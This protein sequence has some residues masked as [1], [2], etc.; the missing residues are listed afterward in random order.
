MVQIL[1]STLREG[2]QTPGVY[3]SPDS[4]LIIARLLDELGVDIIEAGNP[5]VDDE[6]AQSITM[7][8]H[9]GL[10]A[11]VGAHSRCRIDDVKKALHCGVNFIGIF[12]S[13]SEQRLKYD[14][15]I[16]LDEAITQITDVIRYARTQSDN[17]LIRYTA[18]DAVRSPIDNVLKAS[19]AATEA[20]ANIISIA[21][22]TG[23][24][25][26]FKE[27]RKISDYVRILKTELSKK[28]LH[29]KIA[30]HCHNDRGLALANAL[31]A[32]KAGADIIDATVLRL[33]ERTG[34]V[35][36]A[37]LLMNF[38][39]GFEEGLHWR[40]GILK[41][42]Y[43]LVSEYA[44]IPI[45]CNQP[46][47]GK[48]AF[49]H[50]S[51]LHIRALRRDPWLYQSIDPALFDRRWQITLGVQSGRAAVELALERIG[52][53]DVVDN[54]DLVGAIVKEIKAIAKRGRPIDIEEEFPAI[55]ERCERD[56]NFGR[57]HTKY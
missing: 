20:G 56:N 7:I 54:K 57:C 6:I 14:Y 15:N 19:I 47:T 50:C 21:D 52:R 38:R 1:D 4:K 8:A 30:V 22:T 31:D 34:I 39:D 12:L 13:V 40:L 26:P 53:F 17:L 24:S 33:G 46:V 48:N 23:Y 5:M 37:E 35:D 51:G 32:Y 36:L 28:G 45:P 43:E 25:N 41:D 16:T 44:R 42:L 55:V 18:E 29:P 9:E 11:K 49:T 27:G 3:F 2:E 10:R